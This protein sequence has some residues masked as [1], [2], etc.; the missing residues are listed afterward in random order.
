MSDATARQMLARLAAHLAAHANDPAADV[1]TLAEQARQTGELVRAEVIAPT[2]SPP[3]AS[4][5]PHPV[6]KVRVA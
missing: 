4:P 2:C 6:T 1:L 3:E 5:V